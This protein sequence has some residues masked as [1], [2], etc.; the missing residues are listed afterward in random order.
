MICK[1]NII[2]FGKKIRNSIKKEFES[3]PAHNEKYLKTKINSYKG[4]INT[5]FHIHEIPNEGSQCICLSVILIDFIFRTSKI[6]YPDVFLVF[7]VSILL[8]A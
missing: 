6:C 7:L 2:K 5:N 4:K 8:T 3:E 1:K